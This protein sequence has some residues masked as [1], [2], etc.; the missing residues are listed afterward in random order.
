[1]GGFNVFPKRYHREF[2]GDELSEALILY[3]RKNGVPIPSRVNW[4]VDI[5][6]RGVSQKSVV[7]LRGE[8]TEKTD[9]KN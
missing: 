8:A 5:E 6:T 7:I 1:M 4:V 3:L 9:D 2:T